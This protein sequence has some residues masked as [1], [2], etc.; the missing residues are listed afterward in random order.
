[1]LLN[2]VIITSEALWNLRHTKN[3]YV[4]TWKT[5]CITGPLL[6]YPTVTGGLSS[7]SNAELWYFLCC[8]PEHTLKQRLEFPVIGNTM[9]ACDEAVH[10]LA[11][12]TTQD[13]GTSIA[14][15]LEIPKYWTTLQEFPI[16]HVYSIHQMTV[17]CVAMDLLYTNIMNNAYYCQ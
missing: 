13:C 3:H 14:N 6:G 5:F 4:M 9:S 16:L 1:M 10:P 17:Q 11:L 2:K 12:H 8:K 7:Q 15:S